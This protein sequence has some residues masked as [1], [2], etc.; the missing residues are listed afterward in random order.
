M[1]RPKK[2]KEIKITYALRESTSDFDGCVVTLDERSGPLRGYFFF[3]IGRAGRYH[4]RRRHEWPRPS[5]GH[6]HATLQGSRPSGKNA[7]WMSY[8]CENLLLRRGLAQAHTNAHRRETV[9]VPH[10]PLPSCPESQSQETHSAQ[11]P[12]SV[13]ASRGLLTRCL[14]CREG[15]R[16]L[17]DELTVSDVG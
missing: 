1:G 3:L 6:P 16:D 12:V 14:P 11:A 13:A 4:G 10:L 8:L 7:L 5:S 15:V 9:R 17:V 2:K